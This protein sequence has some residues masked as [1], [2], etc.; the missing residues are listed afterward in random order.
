ML[1]LDTLRGALRD[2]RLYVHHVLERCQRIGRYLEPGR[3]EFL[4]SHEYR[5][6]SFAILK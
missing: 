6:P 5:T 3:D 1:T 2:D 4:A